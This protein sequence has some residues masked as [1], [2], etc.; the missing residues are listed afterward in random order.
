M[1]KQEVRIDTPKGERTFDAFF[2]DNGTCYDL[3]QKPENYDEEIEQW[4]EFSGMPLLEAEKQFVSEEPEMPEMA[5]AKYA[6]WRDE[7]YFDN[8]EKAQS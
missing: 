4:M 7:R 3:Y 6:E 5:D 8:L 2:N 1:E